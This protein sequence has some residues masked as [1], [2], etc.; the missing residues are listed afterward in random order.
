MFVVFVGGFL[1]TKKKRKVKKQL[2]KERENRMISESF[3]DIKNS[4]RRGVLLVRRAE[5]SNWLPTA[6]GERGTHLERGGVGYGWSQ[7]TAGK[8]EV[9]VA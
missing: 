3:R 1:F 4:V 8:R 7:G 2:E 9:R 5:T 6:V